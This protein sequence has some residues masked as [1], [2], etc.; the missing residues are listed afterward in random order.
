MH[1]P[2][3]EVTWDIMQMVNKPFLGIDHMFRVWAV[4]PAFCRHFRIGSGAAEG[5]VLFDL[6][7]WDIPRLRELLTSLNTPDT[8][9]A[10][11]QIIGRHI[12]G[13]F[14]ALGHRALQVNIR[15][16]PCPEVGGGE[17]SMTLLVFEDITLRKQTDLTLIE[18]ENH[19]RYFIE[20]ASDM[21]YVHD[22]TGLILALNPAFEA[23]TG[24]PVV[25]WLGKPLTALVH[26]DDRAGLLEMMHRVLSGEPDCAEARIDHCEGR[27]VWLELKGS[28]YR[29]DDMIVGALGVAR[30]VS[31]RHK[32]PARA[33]T[34]RAVSGRR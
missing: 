9:Q 11:V 18:L 6:P 21:M 28:P 34:R 5:R 31:H 15:R 17:N 16:F 32:P 8:G 33:A 29:R 20:A 23:I 1:S 3:H 7:G 10:P 4:N 14:P 2:F 26:I 25:Q 24:Q 13:E 19:Y 12:E 22:H 30:D 27:E